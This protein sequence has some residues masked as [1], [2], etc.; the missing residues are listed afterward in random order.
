MKG[1]S[2]SPPGTASSDDPD[3]SGRASRGAAAYADQCARAGDV[4]GH[5]P[6]PEAC[7]PMLE[8]PALSRKEQQA[9]QTPELTLAS[10]QKQERDRHPFALVRWTTDGSLA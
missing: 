8:T 6:L 2:A 1:V 4:L 5:R 10:G 9:F 7:Q 3:E